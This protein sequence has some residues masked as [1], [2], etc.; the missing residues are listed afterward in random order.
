MP[1]GKILVTG[2]AGYIGSHVA[3]ALRAA[4]MTPVIFDNFSTG[5][6]RL[7][8]P[9]VPVVTADCRDGQALRAALAE[10]SCVAIMH[11]AGSVVVSESIEQPVAYYRNNVTAT[12]EV[13]SACLD[14]GIDSMVFSSTAAVY[15]AVTQ[16]LV[17]EDHRTEPLTPYGHSKLMSEQ[18]LKDC[19]AAN[20]LR[21]IVL[22]YFNV[23]G[24]DPGGRTGQIA[25]DSTHLIKRACEAAH[26]LR[27]ELTV[28]GTDYPTPDGT[29]VR[30]FI[31]VTDLAEAH[32][33]GLRH[34]LAGGPG[35]TMNC[36]YGRGYSVTEVIDE[37]RRQAGS[38]FIVRKGPRRAG[39]APQVVA[40][41]RRVRQILGWQPKHDSLRQIIAD[42][43]AWQA[44]LAETVN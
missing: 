24:A 40:D 44:K 31:H 26:G 9:G 32:V 14:C 21:S 20:G 34:L 18:I 1:T 27:P 15:G 17:D 30:D 43:L 8:P 35:A 28:F 10:H 2:G 23:A 33:L 41:S 36:G 22:R 38:G 19:A 13:V 29:C 7:V 12:L 6:R 3:L 4:G 39:D 25:T 16:P 11:F 5:N 37:V 42:S